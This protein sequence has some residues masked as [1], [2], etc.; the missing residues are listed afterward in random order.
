[1]PASRRQTSISGATTRAASNQ[2]TRSLHFNANEHLCTQPRFEALFPGRRHCAIRDEARPSTLPRCARMRMFSACQCLPTLHDTIGLQ[3]LRART[4]SPPPL[5]LGHSPKPLP[6]FSVFL[7]H[8]TRSTLCHH[9]LYSVP[10][11]ILSTVHHQVHL[12]IISIL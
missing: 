8:L 1:M 10:C 5:A 9:P 11:T 2:G 6:G 3:A 12:T 7:R 4:S